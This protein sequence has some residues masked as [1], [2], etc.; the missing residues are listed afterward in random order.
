[1]KNCLLL[2]KTTEHPDQLGSLDG[3]RIAARGAMEE[4]HLQGIAAVDEGE[5][6]AYLVVDAT[7][8]YTKDNTVLD[9]I[10][11]RVKGGVTRL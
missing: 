4:L 8:S 11:Y 5:V 9:E 6:E 2:V 10:P 3:W 7:Q 1:M